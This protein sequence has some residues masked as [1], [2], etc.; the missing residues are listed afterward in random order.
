[1][2]TNTHED[3]QMVIQQVHLYTPPHTHKHPPTHIYKWQPCSHT[4]THTH[5]HTQ[6]FCVVKN[7]FLS[8]N[9]PPFFCPFSVVCHLHLFSFFVFL[10]FHFSFVYFY[11]AFFSSFSFCFPI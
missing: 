2:H 8:F 11:I 1:M 5:T 9:L 3:T 7:L 4:H 6:D 10:P